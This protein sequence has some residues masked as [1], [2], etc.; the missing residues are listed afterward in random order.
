MPA[1]ALVAP[2]GGLAAPTP[3]KKSSV[4]MNASRGG[5]NDPEL[6]ALADGLRVAH[7]RVANLS[8]LVRPQ[9][10]RHLLVITDLAKRDA[11]LALRRLESFL[12]DL[13][14]DENVP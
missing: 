8:P 13:D 6:D 7:A 1:R 12:S 2:A 14:G 11:A 5:W 4:M 9:M 3:P 10:T